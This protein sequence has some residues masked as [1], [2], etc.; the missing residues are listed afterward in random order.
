MDGSVK[1]LEEY[2]SKGYSVYGMVLRTITVYDT[3]LRLICQQA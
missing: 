2:L 1:L 3:T